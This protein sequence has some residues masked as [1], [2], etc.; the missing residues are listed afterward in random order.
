MM[1]FHWTLSCWILKR[2]VAN[3]L[4]KQVPWSLD[5]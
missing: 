4:A 5:S 1:V 3:P 2:E